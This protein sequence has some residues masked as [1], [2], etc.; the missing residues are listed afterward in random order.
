M[1][2]KRVY[3]MSEVTRNPSLLRKAIPFDITYNGKTVCSVTQPGAKWRECENCGE[4]T[5]NVIDF[6]DKNSQWQQIILCD[7]CGEKLL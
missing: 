2:K 7:K 4:N 3:T 5:K 1:P 6:K